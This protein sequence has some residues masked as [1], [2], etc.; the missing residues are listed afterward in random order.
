MDSTALDEAFKEHIS[1]SLGC[2]FQRL[3]VVSSI[4][5]GFVLRI[6][7][8]GAHGKMLPACVAPS[9]HASL[10]FERLYFLLTS[11]FLRIRGTFVY[12]QRSR[13]AAS[14]EE[15]PTNVFDLRASHAGILL[16]EALASVS[17][18]VV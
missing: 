1:P 3:M 15:L 9:P 17:F 16:P 13:S 12:N 4:A 6:A 7:L 18:G 5:G 10:E 2:C 14:F 11:Y 8:S